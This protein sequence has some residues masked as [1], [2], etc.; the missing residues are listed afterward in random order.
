MN[1]FGKTAFTLLELLCVI[2]LIALLA[3]MMMPALGHVREKAHSTACA[4]NLR[5]IGVAVSLYVSE[6]DNTFPYIETDP[7]NPIL[8][9]DDIPAQPMLETLQP[10]GVS[11]K[12]LECPADVSN[13]NANY[14]AKKQ[15]SYE[16]RPM[17]DGETRVNATIFSRRGA[18]NVPLSR[19]RQVID[20]TAVHNGRQNV[21]YADGRVVAF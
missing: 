20:F 6:H 3:S 11:A 16:W 21:L 1:R 4:A 9:P 7:T 8:Y 2:T 10:Y 15:T 14:Y 19:V 18:I 5:Q 17:I 13:P 12:T